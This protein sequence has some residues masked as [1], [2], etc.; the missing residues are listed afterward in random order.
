MRRCGVTAEKMSTAML[1]S[2]GCRFILPPQEGN[3]EASVTLSQPEMNGCRYSMNYQP[4]KSLDY[5]DNLFTR[6]TKQPTK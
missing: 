4:T 5:I 3:D 1:R 2:E 6:D